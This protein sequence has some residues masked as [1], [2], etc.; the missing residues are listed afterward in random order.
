[1]NPADPKPSV[2]AEAPPVAASRPVPAKAAAKLELLDGGEIIELSLRPSP[3]M[4]ATVAWR[5]VLAA[6]TLAALL[7]I[8]TNGDPDRTGV[9]LIQLLVGVACVFVGFATLQW[10]SKLY[11]LTNRRAIRFRGVFAVGID[12]CPLPRIAT[13]DLRATSVERRLGL[14]TLVMT[15]ATDQFRPVIWEYVSSAADIHAKVVRAIA[16]S[17]G[18]D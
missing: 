9:V 4:I 18:R 8:L 15:P 12:E 11:V 6:A 5:G 7:I 17:T 14:G 1:M 16:R 2:V 3:W 10:S 13:V